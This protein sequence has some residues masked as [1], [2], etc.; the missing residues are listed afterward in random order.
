M[1]RRTESALGP[2]QHLLVKKGDIAYNMMRMWQGA[3]GLASEDGIVS[4]AYVVVRPKKTV[5]PLFASYWFKSERM[6]YL[7]WAYSYGLTND[8]LRLYA[9]DF[10]QIPIELPPLAEQ[11]RIAEVLSDF[12]RTIEATNALVEA[13]QRGKRRHLESLSSQTNSKPVRL[14]KL[15]RFSKGRGIG[16]DEMSQT[17]V[18][19][20]RYAEIYTLYG[21]T[22]TELRSKVPAEAASNSARLLKGDIVFAGSG[23][24]ALEIGK[25][26]TYLGDQ[27]AVVG[28][29]TVIL[30]GHG[31][32]P[33]F[34]AHVLNS[35]EVVR[36][37]YR[38]GQGFSVV[39]IHASELAKIEVR[40]PGIE[41]QRAIAGLFANLDREVA[42][43]I[44]TSRRLE[45]Q[46][47]GLVQR[48][49]TPGQVRE[50]L[51]A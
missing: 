24:T 51:A 6:I 37:K 27:P 25:A 14:G 35:D 28:G 16:K 23:E 22:I 48:L 43:L 39:H 40:L 9:K 29:D 41:S 32:D 36:Q 4:P 17:G 18:S 12:D 30:R 50:A 2:K 10:T 5:D 8:R 46:R 33:S 21:D 20:L 42:A 31:Q 26:V 34:L 1:D 19:C 38:F 15:G 7:F 13:K 45:Q 3:S 47:R 11:R 49:L 44:A